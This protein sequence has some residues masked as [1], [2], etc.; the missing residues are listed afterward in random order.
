MERP[1]RSF[2]LAYGSLWL[3]YAALAAIATALESRAPQQAP[4]WAACH[5]LTGALLGIAV[6][7]WSPGRRLSAH[8]IAAVLFTV[9][10]SG[11]VTLTWSAGSALLF[12][13]FKVPYTGGL[14]KLRW[15]AV[16]GVMAYTA[17]GAGAHVQV[18]ANRLR[19]AQQRAA[20]AQSHRTQAELRALRAQLNPHFLFNTLHAISALLRRDQDSAEDALEH[21]AA[22]LR[23]AIGPSAETDECVSLA[24]EWKMLRHYVAIEKLRLGD[25]LTFEHDVDAEAWGE[26]LPALT[27][28]PL[29]ENAIQHGIAPRARGGKVTVSASVERGR[30]RVSVSDDGVGSNSPTSDDAGLGLRAVRERLEFVYGGRAVMVVDSVKARGFSVT[31]EMPLELEA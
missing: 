11:L 26:R 14:A 24:D 2:W 5:A 20:E 21:F 23:Y 19:L 7:R 31:V 27:L 18:A 29:V 12:E 9:A 3:S 17:I 10:W 6:V 1:P 30:L 25:R 28:Q 16:S 8:V 22:L 4:L 15:Q 13:T